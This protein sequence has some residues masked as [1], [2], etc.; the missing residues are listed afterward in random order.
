MP[1]TL[2]P[3][4]NG[5]SRNWRIRGSV[6]GIHIDETT[7][8]ASRDLAEAIR[9]KREG[10]L[11]DESVFGARASRSF[12]EAA[13][14]YVEKVRPRGT[15]RRAIIGHTRKDGTISQCLVS[16]FGARLVSSIDQAALDEVAVR[17]Y[18]GKKPGTV[19]REL[20]APLVSVLRFA[21][22][23]KWCDVPIF[24]RPRY[25]D[26]RRRWA[27]YEEADRLIA[28]AALH[29]RPALLFLMLTGARMSEALELDWA[30][31]N[32]QQRWL[33]FRGT[34]R[35]SGPDS[36]GEDRGV[37]IHP[38]LVAVLASLPGERSGAV[39]LTHRGLPYSAHD[40]LERGGGGQIKVAWEGACRRARITDLRP[41]DL[42]HSCSTWLTMAGVHE[43]VRD[44][45]LGHQSSDMGRRYSHVPREDLI[46]AIDRLPERGVGVEF[47]P[48]KL[49]RKKTTHFGRRRVAA[50]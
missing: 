12:A 31:V 34:K 22:K 11:L 15:Q 16:D 13:I 26:R 3:P 36:P 44:E 17:R 18:S 50:G 30:D 21:A 49:A 40:R 38:Q 24:E 23:R 2:V 45:I 33:V 19:H 41:H 6:R 1:L 29:V 5:R 20:I 28:A 39:F 27:T 43:R 8:V 48:R 47:R 46:R 25:D 10:Q 9:I 37:P 4:R 35:G 7:G 42:R 14:A 32:L